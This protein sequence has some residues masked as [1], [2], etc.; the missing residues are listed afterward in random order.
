MKIAVDAMGG[1]NAPEV[2]VQGALEAVS[3]FG[4]HVI[5]VGHEALL[6][7]LV[8]APTA[9]SR[10][11]IHHCEDVVAMDESPLKALRKKKDSSIRVAFALD[12]KSVV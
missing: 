11:S 8:G 7:G 1:D 9:D 5:L 3:K 12:R 10:I 4:I 6:E 2:V